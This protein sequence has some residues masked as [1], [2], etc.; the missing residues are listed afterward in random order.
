MRLANPVTYF[1]PVG[2]PL[3]PQVIRA[4]V[5]LGDA[6]RDVPERMMLRVHVAMG[7]GSPLWT[8][9]EYVGD[10]THRMTH[11][12]GWSR[13][14]CDWDGYPYVL[15]KVSSALRGLRHKYGFE[16]DYRENLKAKAAYL[17]VPVE[18]HTQRVRK[19]LLEYADAH[20]QLPVYNRAQWLARQAAVNL[21]LERFDVA[22]RYLSGL[23]KMLKTHGSWC[24]A[25]TEYRLAPNGQP[26]LYEP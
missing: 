6:Q 18:L 16:R 7:D 4:F 21:G 14:P 22:E 8:P 5:D 15:E 24:E 9:V 10:L 11:M 25:A 26:M 12:L 20:A 2:D 13:Y 3:P 19:A 17:G 1:N 23:E